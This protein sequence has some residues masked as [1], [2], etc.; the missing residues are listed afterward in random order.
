MQASHLHPME[1][2]QSTI[3][4]LERLLLHLHHVDVM[5]KEHI[6]SNK[7]KPVLQRV[8]AFNA[9]TSP[10]PS[11]GWWKRDESTSSSSTYPATVSASAC[12][13]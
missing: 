2:P 10:V 13:S 11:N 5:A 12:T 6:P 3:P 8:L 9:N 4:V 7:P 1:E